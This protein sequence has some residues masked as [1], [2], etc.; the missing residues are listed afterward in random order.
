MESQEGSNDSI[1]YPELRLLLED[2]CCDLCRFIHSADGTTAPELITINREAYLGVEGAYADIRVLPP[3]S[4][5]YLVEVKYGYSFEELPRVFARKYGHITPELSEVS[6]VVLVVDTEAED[7]WPI[8]E[9]QLRKCMPNKLPLQVWNWRK[10]A[11]RIN[12]CFQT[13]IESLSEETLLE[14]RTAIDRGKGFHAFGADSIDSYVHDPLKAMLIWHFGFWRLRQLR[15]SAGLNLTEFLVPGT[16]RQVVVVMADLCSYSKYVRDTRDRDLVSQLLTTFYAHTRYEVINHGGM[17][18]RYVGDQVVAFFGIPDQRLDYIVDA[19][20]TAKSLIHIGSSLS[21]D[22]QRRIDHVQETGGLSVSIAMGDVDIVRLRP[23]SRTHLDFVGEM[24]NIGAR[25]NDVAGSNEIVVSN[26]YYQ[27]M[28]H[29]EQADFEEI[30]AVEAKNIGSIGAWR[31]NRDS[32]VNAT[33]T[34]TASEA[35]AQPF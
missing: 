13:S 8:V 11:A 20:D 12:S 3:G 18:Y 14:V 31:L 15:D 10:L 16:Y 4:P 2:I 30:A 23:F 27:S 5:Q 9:E 24:I 29:E 32:G 35:P 21:H 17:L 26:T 25:L 6:K 19:L 7:D 22:W 34:A 33:V 1:P 28:P